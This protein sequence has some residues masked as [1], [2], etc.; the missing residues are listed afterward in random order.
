MLKNPKFRRGKEKKDTGKY[1]VTV[2]IVCFLLYLI[3]RSDSRVYLPGKEGYHKVND[4]PGKEESV[5][6]L[7]EI[8]DR[9]V[10]LIRC[11][12]TKQNGK[13]MSLVEQRFDPKNVQET[14]QNEAGTS[15]TIDKGKELHL[16]L[17]DKR[18]NQHHDI[19]TLMF[20]AIHELAHVM[21]VS[22]GHNSE[23][24]S[25][26]KYLLQNAVECGVYSPVDYKA[27]KKEFC[28]MTIDSSPLFDK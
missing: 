10:K 18:T 19:N 22:Y 20:V 2:L 23:F 1:L 26:F 11:C 17:R 6:L 16:C 24:A 27:N 14:K 9:L 4:I 28:G 12:K 8:S 3:F 25:N 13:D 21:S 15:F 7:E 5:K